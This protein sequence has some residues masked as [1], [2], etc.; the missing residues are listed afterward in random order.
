MPLGRYTT[1]APSASSDE[2][3][4][5][6]IHEYAPRIEAFAR[7]RVP[8]EA[9]AE[10]VVQETIRR[11]LEA[12][13]EG[14]VRCIEAL[15]AFLFETARHVCLHW[16]RREYR[17]ARAVQTVQRSTPAPRTPDP[18][19]RLCREQ[20]ARAVRAAL[21]QLNRRDQ[22]LLVWSYRDGLDAVAIAARLRIE[23]ATVRVRRHR[24]MQRLRAKIGAATG[25]EGR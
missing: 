21:A 16:L 22:D 10:D 6:V 15:P 25:E 14:R 11:C 2:P 20:D 5:A 7:R 23:A 24:A 18:S 9:A 4:V 17:E 12:L 8:D 19:D 3:L 1:T 13:R